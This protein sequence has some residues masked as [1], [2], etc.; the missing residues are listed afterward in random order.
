MFWYA[1][2]KHWVMVLNERDGHS[3]YTSSDLKKCDY[4]SHTIGFWE[5]P[6]L[7]ELPVE[8][9]ES[10]KKWVMYGASNTYMIGAF[11]GKEFTPESGKYY[12]SSGTIYTAQTYNNIPKSD[13]RRI[14]IG[15]GRVPQK[16]ISFNNMMLL[17]TELTLPTTKDGVRLFSNPVEEVAQLFSPVKKWNGLTSADA[18]EKMKEFYEADRLRIKT[19]IKLSHATDAGFNLFGQRIIGYDLNFNLLN[20]MFYSP[21]DPT[22]MELTADIFID[23]TSIEVFIDGG[24][25]SYSM[26]RKPDAKNTEGFHFWGNRITVEELEVYSVKSIWE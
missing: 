6:D 2:S 12:F 21:E 10:N 5:C 3:I 7:F 19:K 8:R 20:G 23:R 26:E 15:W 1:P 11:D 4:Q 25:Y 14:Q 22:S 13:G 18:N 24:K 17:P 9:D 16:E